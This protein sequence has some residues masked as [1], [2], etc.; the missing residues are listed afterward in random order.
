MRRIKKSEREK[1]K[2]KGKYIHAFWILGYFFPSV[3]LAAPDTSR[4]LQ[5]IYN[6]IHSWYVSFLLPFGSVLAGIVIIIGGIMYST[7]GGDSA[8][9]GRA[10]ELIIGA[11]TGLV[12]LICAALIIRTIIY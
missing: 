9:T 2:D 10:K 11:L 6:I 5:A 8:K 1:G 12:L 4:D 3:A 7:S